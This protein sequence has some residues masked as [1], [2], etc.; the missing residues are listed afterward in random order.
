MVLI[1]LITQSLLPEAYSPVEMIIH[2][3]EKINDT[4]ARYKK[5]ELRVLKRN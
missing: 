1:L 4:M 3:P 5:K 2:I